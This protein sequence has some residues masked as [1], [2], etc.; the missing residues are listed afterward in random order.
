M[1]LSSLRIEYANKRRRD[2]VD[3]HSTIRENYYTRAEPYMR[4][5]T[6]RYIE[7]L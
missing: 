2:Y 3:F 6:W 4:L 5:L 1:L 7:H